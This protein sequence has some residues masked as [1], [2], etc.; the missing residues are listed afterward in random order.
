MVT[1]YL[2]VALLPVLWIYSLLLLL[3]VVWFLLT[4]NQNRLSQV[5]IAGAMALTFISPAF[6]I[7]AVPYVSIAVL[8]AGLALLPQQ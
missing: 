7:E 1:F 6:G 4:T 5:L 2:S 8:L 3:P